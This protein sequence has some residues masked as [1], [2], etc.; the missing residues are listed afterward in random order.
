MIHR[1]PA[2]CPT[3]NVTCHPSDKLAS[4]F[5]H[6]FSFFFLS[7]GQGVQP[8]EAHEYHI[9][10]IIQRFIPKTLIIPS[11]PNSP[12]DSPT[13]KEDQVGISL[14]VVHPNTKDIINITRDKR[15]AQR[16]LNHPPHISGHRTF[17]EKV[18]N[19]FSSAIEH[20]VNCTLLVSLS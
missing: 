15:N 9:R 12:H 10:R 5:H 13:T 20:T 1:S 17:K 11:P 6:P 19:G 3:Q 16:N 7:E 8:K 2:E 18:V 14:E 4:L